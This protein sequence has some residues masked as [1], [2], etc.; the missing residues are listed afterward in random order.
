[1]D[2]D[3]TSACHALTLASAASQTGRD[4]PFRDCN[5][6][7]PASSSWLVAI[8]STLRPRRA[9]VSDDAAGRRGMAELLADWR[10]A[11]RDTAAA[12]E[13]ARI[14]GLA[15]EAAKAAVAAANDVEATA[16]AALEAVEQARTAA[17]RARETASKAAEAAALVVAEA[18]G[19]QAQAAD[20]VEHAEQAEA[21]ARD[22]F[23]KAEADA[24][25][26]NNG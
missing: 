25:N 4:H 8:V 15:L 10:A 3:R 5:V 18:Q 13:A 7:S 24:R 11:G 17:I 23:H 6:L 20:D 12:F 14:A 16:A 22:A 19:S 26:A 2:G 21:A 9:T 1:V